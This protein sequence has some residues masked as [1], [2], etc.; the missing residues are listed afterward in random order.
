MVERDLL[1]VRTLFGPVRLGPPIASA[2]TSVTYRV[3]AE[4][5]ALD[6]AMT[7]DADGHVLTA[8]WTPCTIRPPLVEAR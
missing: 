2:A 8:A 4:R 7:M 5:G 3:A 1:M 6:L